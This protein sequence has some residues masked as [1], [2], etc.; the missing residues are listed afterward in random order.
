[1]IVF[2]AFGPAAATRSMA[3]RAACTEACVVSIGFSRD[4]WQ[5]RQLLSMNAFPKFAY[6]SA[7]VCGHVLPVGVPLAGELA[8]PA[9]ESIEAKAKANLR[10]FGITSRSCRRHRKRITREGLDPRRKRSTCEC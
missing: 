2:V 1:M 7:E 8:Q 10:G 5:A 3:S 4:E 9:A 6:V